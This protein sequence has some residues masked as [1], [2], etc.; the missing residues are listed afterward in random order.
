MT[1]ADRQASYTVLSERGVIAIGGDDRVTFLQGLVSNDIRLCSPTRAIYTWFMTPQGKYL[2]DFLVIETGDALLLDVEAP[3]REDLLKRLKM[4]KLRSKIT[5]EDRTGT[6]AVAA[7][8]GGEALR[9]LGLAGAERG[10]V[11]PLGT[12][13]ALAD[14]RK[15]ELGGRVILPAGEIDATLTPAGLVAAP[16]ADYD[17]LRLELGVADGSR[18]LVPERS[19]ALE[20]DMDTLGAL[21]WDKGCYMGQELNARTKYR[22]LTKKR[23]VTVTL[24]GPAPAAGTPVTRGG[25]DVGELRSSHGGLALALLRIDELDNF[26]AEPGGDAFIAEGTVITIRQ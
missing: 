11:L 15:A 22:G 21:S 5:L 7:V 23:L 3:R 26:I 20:N 6:L 25:R 24:N 19:I 10:S 16:F 8:Y 1:S 17:T 4:Y 18:D 13:F 9:S 12:G 2:H 14:P